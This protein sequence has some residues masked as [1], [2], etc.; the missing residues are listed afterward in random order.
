M[1]KTTEGKFLG[2]LV[3]SANLVVFQQSSRVRAARARAA[4]VMRFH[5]AYLERELNEAGKTNTVDIYPV[6][7]AE[8]TFTSGLWC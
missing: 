7:T 4:V 3:K 1:R 5:A 8:L 6:R 2:K